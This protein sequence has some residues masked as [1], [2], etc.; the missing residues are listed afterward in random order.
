MDRLHRD[1]PL[2]N[3]NANVDSGV[4]R[5]PLL[6]FTLVLGS[7]PFGRLHRAYVK[8]MFDFRKSQGHP[9]NYQARRSSHRPL[10]LQARK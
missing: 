3:E 2:Q 6:S 5:A 8:N 4:C 1:D 7:I 10:H 9:L